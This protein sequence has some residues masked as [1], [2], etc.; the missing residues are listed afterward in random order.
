ME[1]GYF[2]GRPSEIFVRLTTRAGA[3]LRVQV[4]GR[5]SVQRSRLVRY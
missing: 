1:Q 4:G 5:A 3:I 2:M